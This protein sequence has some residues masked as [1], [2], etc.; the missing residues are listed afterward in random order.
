MKAERRCQCCG[1][2]F[3]PRPQNPNQHC[4]SEAACQRER[5]RRWQRRKRG[6][7]PDYR[8]NEQAAQRRWAG[9]HRSYWRQWREAHPDYVER[10]RA[11]QRARNARRGG[12]AN[13]ASTIANEDA[14]T[15]ETLFRSG[16]YQVRPWP[17]GEDCKC[18]CVSAG[19]L[20]VINAV[21]IEDGAAGGD[22]K[23]RTR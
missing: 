19:R 21:A 14:S 20:F 6:T 1:R 7:D 11:A 23:E 5:K 9:E 4:C 3:R 18:G 2:A 8:A 10:N 13:D 16:T 12:G 22:C 17:A 15:A